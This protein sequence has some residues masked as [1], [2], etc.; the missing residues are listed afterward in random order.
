MHFGDIS[1]PLVTVNG[2][3]PSLSWLASK[4][5]QEQSAPRQDQTN[6]QKN[7][8][9]RVNATTTKTRKHRFGLSNQGWA[10]LGA[11]GSAIGGAFAAISYF[12]GD[13]HLTV[14]ATSESPTFT[15]VATE[16]ALKYEIRVEKDFLREAEKLSGQVSLDMPDFI[17]LFPP[18]DRAK[19]TI[20]WFECLAPQFDHT[21]DGSR[22]VF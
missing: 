3:D 16:C 13:M 2:S 22:I 8:N 17:K 20:A 5:W 11:V 10:I 7:K 4:R 1:I 18:N 19:V 6:Y 21:P 12:S 15:K 9:T 14:S